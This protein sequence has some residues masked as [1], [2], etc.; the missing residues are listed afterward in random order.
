MAMKLTDVQA[1]GSIKEVIF[2]VV[3]S[4][5]NVVRRFPFRVGKES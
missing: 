5:F 2:I 1:E 3:I 4:L